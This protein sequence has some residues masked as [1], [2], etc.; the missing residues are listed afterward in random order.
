MSNIELFREIENSRAEMVE[1]LMALVRIPAIGPENGGEGESKKAEKVSQ[2]LGGVGFD[3]VQHFDAEDSRVPSK[4]RPNFVAFVR[5]DIGKRIWIITH[6]D[7][8]PAG[9]SDLW[10]VAK[11]FGPVLKDNRV[12]GRGTEDN[13][14][15]LVASIYAVKAI[16]RLGLKPKRTVALGIVSDEEQ[17]NTLG[18]QHLID[19]G[20]FRKDDLIL[21]PDGGS[22]D[23]SFIEVA[24]KSILW[25]KLHT[26]GKQSHASLPNKGLNA[27]RIGMQISLALDRMLHEKYALKDEKYDVPESTFEITKKDSN[28]EAVNII[29]GEDTVY[30]DCRILPNYD[31]DEV[32]SEIMKV[33]AEFEKNTGAKISLEV[34]QKQVS[35]DSKSAD[36][37]IV[38]QLK[39]AL[40]DARGLEARVGGLG[41]GTCAA[42]FRKAGFP[43]VVWSTVDEVAHQSNEYSKVQNMVNDAKVF[44]LLALS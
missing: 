28:V 33:I 16:R 34:L 23:G 39:K 11:P 1:T 25:F 14:Q 19:K 8:V 21:V 43:A 18:I 13:G 29:P 2:L 36:S 3:E 30:F 24:E 42:F 26:I 7:V 40:K 31:V 10:T 6:M 12:Y 17:G 44:A 38:V 41:G 32:L 35:K 5:G 4:K 15:S 22:E 37:E 27:H 9:D 20:I